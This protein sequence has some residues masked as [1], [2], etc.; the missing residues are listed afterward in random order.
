MRWYYFIRAG[1][2]L[3]LPKDRYRVPPRPLD[4]NPANGDPLT[5]WY[6]AEDHL[7]DAHVHV[8]AAS[9]E[10]A[11]TKAHDLITQAPSHMPL[12]GGSSLIGHLG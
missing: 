11:E 5:P 3:L 9:V 1:D 10:E 4:A 12:R 2:K 8:R 6:T 7:D